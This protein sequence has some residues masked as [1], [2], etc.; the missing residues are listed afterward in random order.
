MVRTA[1]QKKHQ[2]LQ[3][4][5]QRDTS[6]EAEVF[7]VRAELDDGRM[8][9][10]LKGE[11]DLATA[12]ILERAIGAIPWEHLRELA[13]DLH[14]L[15]FIDSTGLT[16]IIRTAQSAADEGVQFA[17]QR[18]PDQARRLFE[19]TGVIERLGVQG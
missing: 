19:I 2:N 11:L 15:A 1:H 8:T 12:P 5:P 7:A 4:P 10:S 17:I 3:T 18:V 16:L 14:D 9:L 6:V 13:F